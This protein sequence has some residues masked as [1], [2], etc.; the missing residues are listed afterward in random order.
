[1]VDHLFPFI[2]VRSGTV[3]ISTFPPPFSSVANKTPLHV[4]MISRPAP[5]PSRSIAVVTNHTLPD[6]P[7]AGH[8]GQTHRGAR[9]YFRAASHVLT[10]ERD[11]R[12]FIISYRLERR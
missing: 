5:P 7:S 4:N 2:G 9:H 6:W 8:A 3:G 1:M 11:T 12:E 10:S